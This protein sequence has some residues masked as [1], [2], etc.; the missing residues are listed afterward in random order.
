VSVQS[1]TRT[2][3]VLSANPALGAILGREIEAAGEY[4]VPVFSSLP[5]LSTFLRITPV[6]VAILSLDLPWAE[7]TATVRTLKH[8]PAVAS[9]LLEIIVLSHAVPLAGVDARE[10][11]AVLRKPASPSE[12]LAAIETVLNRPH[13][14]L[15]PAT[16]L[17]AARLQPRAERRPTSLLD[18][19]GSNVIPL[20]GRNRP[21]ARPGV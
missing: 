5:A 16:P 7:V 13:P 2:I 18:G 19:V 8:A 12:V 3:A 20:F 21:P 10:I 4:R 15:R 17:R 11:A 6:D 9:P 14:V 1:R